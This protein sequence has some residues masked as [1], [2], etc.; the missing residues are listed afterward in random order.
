MRHPFKIIHSPRFDPPERTPDERAGHRPVGRE[1]EFRHVL[2][3]LWES[4]E[5]VWWVAGGY[6]TAAVFLA[7]LPSVGD[8]KIGARSTVLYAAIAV[9]AW[10]GSGYFR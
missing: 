9:V 3:P 1:P 6:L 10:L 2:V 7:S 8:W 4:R 5:L